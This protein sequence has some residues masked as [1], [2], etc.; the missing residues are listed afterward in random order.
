MV[1]QGPSLWAGA[2]GSVTLPSPPLTDHAPQPGTHAQRP[3]TEPNGC[4]PALP[5]G[6]HDGPAPDLLPSGA[7]RWCPHWTPG[8]QR[9]QGREAMGE[10]PLQEQRPER[11]GPLTGAQFPHRHSKCLDQVGVGLP[12][13]APDLPVPEGWAGLAASKGRAQAR[14]ATRPGL[15][16]GHL[17]GSRA[18]EGRAQSWCSGRASCAAGS[19][20]VP[21]SAPGLAVLTPSTCGPRGLAQ[22]SPLCGRGLPPRPA[23]QPHQPPRAPSSS[24][25]GGGRRVSGPL[26]GPPGAARSPGQASRTQGVFGTKEQPGPQDVE[27]GPSLPPTR[28]VPSRGLPRVGRD[29]KPVH[30]KRRR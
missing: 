4:P 15:A 2:W 23:G 7:P 16:R 13:K 12:C 11:W 18:A 3:R 26:G 6:R 1:C 28:C 10:Q 30:T 20:P 14:A 21:S 17:E 24:R 22:H 27:P 29:P 25:G 9:G 8:A 19:G 5:R